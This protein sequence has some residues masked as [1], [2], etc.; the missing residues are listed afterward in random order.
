MLSRLDALGEGAK[1]SHLRG[2]EFSY[3]RRA[4]ARYNLGKYEAAVEDYHEALALAGERA[5]R[6]P[7]DSDARR[8]LATYNGEM[9]YS[10]MA[11]ERF[12]EAEQSLLSATDWFQA[13]YDEDPDIGSNQRAIMVQHVQLHEFYKAR[14]P[15]REEERCY[16]LAQVKHF[17]DVQ[18][19][20]GTLLD[21]D[22]PE[23][24]AYLEANPL[25]EN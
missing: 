23:L 17:W 8:S 19:E 12:D 11:L 9:A 6:D 13:R 16:H 15:E 2:L 5:R 20:A 18:A 7:N 24:E 25:C 1:Q 10:L 21:S 14:G 4:F 22:L 3:W